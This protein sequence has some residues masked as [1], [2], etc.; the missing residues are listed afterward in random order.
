MASRA[1]KT[2]SPRDTGCALPETA[3]VVATL[4]INSLIASRLKIKELTT[5]RINFRVYETSP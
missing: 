5:G 3:S 4:A 1:L 2:V